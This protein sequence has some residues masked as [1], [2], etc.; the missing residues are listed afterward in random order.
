MLC[1]VFCRRTED[2]IPV[3][4]AASAPLG[5]LC[6]D[7]VLSSLPSC[8]VPPCTVKGVGGRGRRLEEQFA[9]FPHR[10]NDSSKS[11][12]VVKHRDDEERFV[13][14]E[15]FPSDTRSGM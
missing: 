13:T 3:D 14:P 8:G 10:G 9:C 11:F 5:A 12:S 1:P 15:P 4:D 2:V 6:L 7:P